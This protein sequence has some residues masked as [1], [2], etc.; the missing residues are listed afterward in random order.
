MS[1]LCKTPSEE[2]CISI[3]EHAGSTQSQGKGSEALMPAQVHMR[4]KR[5]KSCPPRAN[6]SVISGPWSLEW[7]QDHNHG[8]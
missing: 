5:T 8:D 6:R 7:L 4:R 3:Q 1:R 2:V